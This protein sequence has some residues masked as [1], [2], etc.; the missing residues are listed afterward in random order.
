MSKENK[1][2][3]QAKLLRTFRKVH[4]TT[5]ALLFVFFFVM[6]VT[7]LLLGWKKNS[8]GIILAETRTGVSQ[9]FKNW[10]PMDLLH[11][12]AVQVYKDSISAEGPVTVD[13]IDIRKNKGMLKFTFEGN[14]WGIQMDGA[15]G[16]PLYIEKRRGDY[17]EKLHDGS[18]LDHYLGVKNGW[19][20]LF[21]TT[22]MGTALFIFTAT[23]FWLWYGPKRMRKGHANS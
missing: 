4:R 13:R 16:K 8:S 20:K 21:Y 10:L 22:V 9:D 14:F 17:I 18:I 7:G 1:R 3:Q 5:G 19:I 15:T 23:G 6:S 12:N 2:K 11:Q